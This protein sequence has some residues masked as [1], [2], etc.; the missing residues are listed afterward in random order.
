GEPPPNV[1]WFVNDEPFNGQIDRP[2]PKVIVNKLSM[3]RIKRDRLNSTFKCLATNT[4]LMQP[5]ERS[6]RLEMYLRPISVRL[7]SKPE[8]LIADQEYTI[9]CQAI[10]SRPQAEITW[11]RENK[12]FRRGKVC[13]MLIS[14]IKYCR[15]MGCHSSTMTWG[16]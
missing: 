6:L 16:H 8:T 3:T 13:F 15:V 5:T 12:K 9:G 2:G 4:K 1:T 10:G 14:P 11:L 7:T